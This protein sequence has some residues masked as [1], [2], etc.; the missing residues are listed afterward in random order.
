MELVGQGFLGWK[1]YHCMLLQSYWQ[2]RKALFFHDLQ[3]S[4]FPCVAT[5]AF[6]APVHW[7]GPSPDGEADTKQLLSAVVAPEAMVTASQTQPKTQ[8]VLL[9]FFNILIVSIGNHPSALRGARGRVQLL[10]LLK[11]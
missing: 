11:V 4:G 5:W 6:S 9:V 8:G 3:V 10:I 1:I 2:M 7:L